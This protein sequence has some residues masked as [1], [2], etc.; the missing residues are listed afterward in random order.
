MSTNLAQGI[1][2]KDSFENVDDKSREKEMKIQIDL[3][4]I[5]LRSQNIKSTTT[6]ETV[7]TNETWSKI[8]SKLPGRTDKVIKNAWNRGLTIHVQVKQT[9]GRQYFF[10][11][12]TANYISNNN[13]EKI[14]SLIIIM[15]K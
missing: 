14:I 15:K 5:L 12:L 11:S 1:S 2:A 4:E 3:R 8:A 6:E 9:Q 13:H 7:M 10:T